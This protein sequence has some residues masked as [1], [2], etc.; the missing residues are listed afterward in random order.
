MCNKT[1]R[2][3]PLPALLGLLASG[4]ASTAELDDWQ[5]PLTL[6][7]G[8]ASD[9]DR[10]LQTA[11][12]IEP[13][14]TFSFSGGAQSVVSVRARADAV[15]RLQP[16]EPGFESYSNLSRPHHLGKQVTV[17]LR[18]AYV[19]LRINNGIARLGKQQIVWG[20]LDGLKVLDVLNPQSYRE[21]ILEDFGD[22]RIGLWS[23]Y[24]DRSVGDWR[25]ELALIPDSSG[26]EIPED[27]AWFQLTAPRFRYG[28]LP[29]QLA[30]P[31]RTRRSDSLEDTAIGLQ[32]SRF[33]GSFGV[34]SVF[35]SGQEHEPLGRIV[36]DESAGQAQPVLERYY[37]R[38][39]LIGLNADT[40][41]G[42]LALRGEFAWQPER[43]FN[44]RNESG[45]GEIRRDQFTAAL[46]ADYFAPLGVF[47][48]AQL[49]IDNVRNATPG[50]VRPPRDR[51]ATITLR[52][53]FAYETITTELRAYRSLDNRD[54]LFSAKLSYELGMDSEVSLRAES[55][56]GNQR[57]LFGQFRGRDR[58]GLSLRHYF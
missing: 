23:A 12:E 50:M 4:I 44:T 13:R 34:S 40:S 58:I 14:L 11:L 43:R 36:V 53:S 56:H 47:V 8:W 10:E 46:A 49:Q 48:N 18:D 31:M 9:A 1:N 51:V 3:W 30:P 33:I 5:L 57:G 41:I 2:R 15:D 35:Y 25:V 38:R 19:E 52:R 28:A 17:E 42:A 55:F 54:G 27:G 21:F 7:K 37:G 39:Q 29:G 32:L 24:V 20:R 22:S 45:L 16:G 6:T 26:H